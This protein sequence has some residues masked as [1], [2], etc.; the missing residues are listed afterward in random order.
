MFKSGTITIVVDCLDSDNDSYEDNV[1]I[2]DDNDGISD[3]EEGFDCQSPTYN[4]STDEWSGTLAITWSS[5]FPSSSG[6]IQY[7]GVDPVTTANIQG[8]VG[9]FNI[10]ET[11]VTLTR[12]TSGSY[13][14]G[15]GSQRA[16]YRIN[17]NQSHVSLCWPNCLICATSTNT[18]MSVHKFTFKSSFQFSFQNQ[19]C[20]LWKWGI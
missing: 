7:N 9:T 18:G 2:D 3:I 16:Y 14:I 15:S 17:N 12:S 13:S 6:S 11:N 8:T 5:L 10:G 19:W 20:G 4:N 1:D